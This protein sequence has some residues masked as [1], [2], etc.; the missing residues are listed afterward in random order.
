[1]NYLARLKALTAQNSKKHLSHELTEPTKGG[2]E[3]SKEAFVSFVSTHGRRFS[4]R[5]DE[6]DAIDERAALAAASVPACYLDVWAA[7]QIQ[8][9]HHIDS[10]SWQLAID[11][12]GRF[13]DAWGSLAVDMNWSAGDLFDAP[14]G[15]QPCGLVWELKGGRVGALGEDHARLSD[16]RTIERRR[17]VSLRE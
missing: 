7:L 9:P 8:R 16:G 12:A 13:L 1:M 2:Q 11:D 5:D 10:A 3:P 6:S 15:G 4:K 14:K 17:N